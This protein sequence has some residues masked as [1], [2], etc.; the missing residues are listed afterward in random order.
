LENPAEND[1]NEVHLKVRLVALG[2]YNIPGVSHVRERCTDESH[3][4]DLEEHFN[5]I[6]N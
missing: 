2:T 4:Q 6:K 5:G 1:N 3:G